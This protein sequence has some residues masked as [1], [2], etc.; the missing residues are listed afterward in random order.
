MNK[1]EALELELAARKMVEGTALEWGAVIRHCPT[2]QKL[3]NPIDFYNTN[4]V[5]VAL[6]I[7]EGK[8]VWEGDTL[9]NIITGKEYTATY[10]LNNPTDWSWNPPKPKTV[11]VELTVENAEYFAVNYADNSYCQT[12]TIEIAKACRKALENLK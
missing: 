3:G 6:G 8:P 7:L 10:R 11:M 5:D 9:W 4:H 12:R 2:K 1:I